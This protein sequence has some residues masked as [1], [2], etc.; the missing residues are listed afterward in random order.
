MDKCSVC[1]K[2]IDVRI[3]ELIT[4]NECDIEVCCN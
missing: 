1:H 3:N 2:Q 4:C